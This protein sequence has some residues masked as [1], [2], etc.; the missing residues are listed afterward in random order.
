MTQGKWNRVVLRDICDSVKYG[1]T[2]SAKSEPIGPKFLRITD[3]V[4]NHIDWS[5]VPHCEINEDNLSKYLLEKDDIVIARTGATTGYAKR[6]RTKQHAIFASYLVRI[7]I[8]SKCDSKYIGYIVE[9]DE[10]KQFIQLN[11]GGAAQPHANAQILTSFPISLPPP[12]TQ[13]KIAAILSAYDDLIENNTRRIKILED[14]AQ[15]L[16]QEWFVH[17]RFPG[18]E[19]VSMVESKLGQIPQGWEVVHFSDILDLVR[20]GINPTKFPEEIFAHFSIPA[21]DNE[22]MPILHNGNSIKS[23]KYLVTKGCVLLSKL[24]P[25]IPRVWLPFINTEHRAISSTE[26]LILKPKLP[27]DCMFL[28]NLCRSPEFTDKFAVRALGTSGSHQ[29]VKPDDFL[30]MSL[31]IP[32]K[33]LLN[34]FQKKVSPL[35]NIC[36]TLRLKNANLRQTRDLLLRKL[37]SGEIDV[38]ELDIIRDSTI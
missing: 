2:S 34:G 37:I 32:T 6:I 8:N 35:V 19:N 26:F 12:Q 14:M 17:Y 23:S 13:Q 18:H 36:N 10:Y 28:Y 31:I 30:N 7:R 24:N 9:S 4:P 29:R 1:Y 20:N 15:T 33:S 25:R 3:I 27:V 16:Y 22:H 11:I 38:S 5:S 21:F